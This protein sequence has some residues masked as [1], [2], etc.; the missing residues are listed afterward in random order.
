MASDSATL[1]QI[2]VTK[3]GYTPL[4]YTVQGLPNPDWNIPTVCNLDISNNI[5]NLYIHNRYSDSII[6]DVIILVLY[7]RNI[8]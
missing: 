3:D 1:V 4:L 5:A 6:G 8:E 2:N 7:K